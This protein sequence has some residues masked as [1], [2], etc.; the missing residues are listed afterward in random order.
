MADAPVRT[1]L[2]G[3]GGPLGVLDAMG[4]GWRLMAS[5]FWRLWLVGLVMMLV[6]SAAGMFGL[7]AAILVSPP[8]MAGMF[9]VVMR[10]IEGGPAEVGDLFAGFKERFGESVIGYLPVSLG[11]VV[12][13]G[14]LGVLGWVLM[15]AF[16][17]GAAA[18][19]E[20]EAAAAGIVLAGA[21][22]F[23]AIM[24]CLLV[25]LALLTLFFLLVPAAVWDHPGAGWE[26]AKTS[27]RLARDHFVSMLGLLVLFGLISSAANLVG[28]L[29]CCVGW[30]FT[31]PAVTVWFYA[32]VA[33]LYRSWMGQALTQ[34]LAEGAADEFPP[35]PGEGY[36]GGE[37]PVPAGNA[38]PAGP[39]DLQPPPA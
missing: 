20:N 9:Y 7:P 36:E 30:V 12:I 31:V 27:V 13:G 4:L 19:E 23:L 35:P 18:A 17:G 8:M 39:G 5:D 21:L 2:A 32:T 3:A 26:A 33:Y 25:G 22:A 34:P 38:G 1:S 6:A 29:A 10:R 11:S 14:L 15:M 37:G 24:G 16:V 28:M